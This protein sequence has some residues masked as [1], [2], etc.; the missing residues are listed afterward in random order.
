MNRFVPE[1][2]WRLQLGF[3]RLK[4][5]FQTELEGL[6]WREG[7]EWPKALQWGLSAFIFVLILALGWPL[8]VDPARADL[9]KSQAQSQQLKTQFISRMAVWREA[10]SVHQQSE[11]LQSRLHQLEKQLPQK[12][13]LPNLMLSLDQSAIQHQLQFEWLK[14]GAEHLENGLIEVPIQMRL[15]GRFVDVALFCAA[16]ARLPRIVTL[17]QWT[18]VRE[19]VPQSE[20]LLWTVRASTYRFVGEPT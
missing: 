6:S 20:R 11:A 1:L 19:P 12:A 13:E 3:D 14:P 7:G 10:Q 17:N 4:G 15:T 8:L 9:G 5:L 16:V 18:L 2:K